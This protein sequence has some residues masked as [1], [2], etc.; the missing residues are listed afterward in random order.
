MRLSGGREE[1]VAA[2]PELRVVAADVL[3]TLGP[4]VSFVSTHV[5]GISPPWRR[6]RPPMAAA[7]LRIGPFTDCGSIGPEP[8]ELFQQAKG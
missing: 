5:G 2:S 6:D 7:A 3:L 8:V 4:S 1:R